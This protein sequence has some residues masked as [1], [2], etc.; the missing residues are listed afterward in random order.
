[1]TEKSPIRILFIL[2]NSY[3]KYKKIAILRFFYLLTTRT[4]DN[5]G[6][7]LAS[8]VGRTTDRPDIS[9]SLDECIILT[10]EQLAISLLRDK[11]HHLSLIACDTVD[12]ASTLLNKLISW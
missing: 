3:S 9:L 8:A 7:D 4:F 6:K 5:I 1:M 11:R 12:T 10:M 2:T